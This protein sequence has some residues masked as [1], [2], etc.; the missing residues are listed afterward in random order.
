LHT[1]NGV[2][3]R[4]FTVTSYSENDGRLVTITGDGHPVVFNFG[5]SSNVNLRG[6]VALNNIGEDQVLWNFTT[7]G[8]E[9]NLNTNASSYHLPLGYRGT[10]L[11]PNDK[12]SVVNSNL[13]G[14]VIGGNS[15]DMQIVSGDTI[16]APVPPLSN[17]A[18]VSA[19]NVGAIS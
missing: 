14:R 8:K 1:L 5:F 17:I 7:T 3:Y 2:D 18:T 6:D 19:D 15:S 13:I 9:I 16:I 12:I 4:V 11:A 10:I